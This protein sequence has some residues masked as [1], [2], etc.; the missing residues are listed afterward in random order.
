MNMKHIFFIFLLFCFPTLAIAQ[1]GLDEQI[2]AGF[3]SAT[4]WFVEGIFAQI[5]LT[6][7]V[8]VPWVLVVLIVGASFF[9]IYFRG[10]NLRSF[11]TAFKIVRGKYDD[12]ELQPDS[13]EDNI[14]TIGT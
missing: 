4:G 6:N 10:I 1:S 8:G 2:N 3:E 13:V 14:N 7:E 12:I 11:G 5:P 9:T